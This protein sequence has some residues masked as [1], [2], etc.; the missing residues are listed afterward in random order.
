MLGYCFVEWYSYGVGAVDGD[1]WELVGVYPVVDGVFVAV[2]ELG[3]LF[4]CE[5]C[6]LFHIIYYIMFAR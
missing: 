1:V 4:D 6:F 2:H 3:E 5:V